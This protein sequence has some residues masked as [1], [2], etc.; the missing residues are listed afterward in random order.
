WSPPMTWRFSWC[1]GRA[2]PQ[3]AV[4]APLA[5]VDL[6][7]AVARL[8]DLIGGRRLGLALAPPRHPGSSPRGARLPEPAA[9]ALRAPGREGVVVGNRAHAIRVADDDDFRRRPA[10]DLGEELVDDLLGLRREV[11]GVLEKIEVEG[12]RSRRLGRERR[13]EGL[14]DFRLRGLRAR[15]AAGL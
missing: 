4:R 12:H 10:S 6:D 1:A 2:E 15:D 9:P 11:V 7:A 5:D 13:A 3:P 14:P 8:G